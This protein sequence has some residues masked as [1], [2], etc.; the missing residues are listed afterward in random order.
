[1]NSARPWRMHTV[2]L[3]GPRPLGFHRAT[4]RCIP[5]AATTSMT[6]GLPGIGLSG[7]A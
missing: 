5:S 1:M 4:R 3:A 2:P 6:T 7:V